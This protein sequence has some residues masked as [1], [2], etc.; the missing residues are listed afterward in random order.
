MT[1]LVVF[2]LAFVSGFAFGVVRGLK[3]SGFKLE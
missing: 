1:Y 3:M 2:L